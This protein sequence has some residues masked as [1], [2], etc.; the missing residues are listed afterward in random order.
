MNFEDPPW[1]QGSLP[2]K[3][4]EVKFLYS[5]TQA[6]AL[7]AE[8]AANKSMGNVDKMKLRTFTVGNR[9]KNER[10]GAGGEIALTHILTIPIESWLGA[11]F[12][13]RGRGDV[14]NVEVR[15]TAVPNGRLMV[16]AR[17]FKK[18]KGDRAFALLY[19]SPDLVTYEFVG[20]ERGHVV[21]EKGFV[22][23]YGNGEM[24]WALDANKLRCPYEMVERF[25][26]WMENKG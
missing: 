19:A 18:G 14:C 15:S 7:M 11:D 1:L 20:W 3:K 5:L 26:I 4:P 6:E 13:T 12:A 8:A 16:N 2:E 24:T 23:D 10:T 25:C 21:R 22:R 9:W 17:D